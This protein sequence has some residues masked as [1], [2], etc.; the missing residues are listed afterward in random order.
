MTVVDL[1]AEAA[2]HGFLLVIEEHGSQGTVWQWRRGT[3]RSW[4]SFLTEREAIGWME[5]R[6]R[7][8]TLLTAHR[9]PTIM[10]TRVLRAAP[11]SR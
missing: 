8:G 11:R 4:P 7:T 5:H 6:I 10:P 3:D 9:S 1:S 2:K